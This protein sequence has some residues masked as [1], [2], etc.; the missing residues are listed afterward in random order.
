M[1]YNILLLIIIASFVIFYLNNNANDTFKGDDYI[2]NT[3]MY[4]FLGIILVII[5]AMHTNDNPTLKHYISTR[6]GAIMNMLMMFLCLFIVMMT[7]QNKPV[8]KH[9]AWTT[10]MLCLGMFIFLNYKFMRKGSTTNAALTTLILIIGLS[11]FSYSLS[12]NALPQ[13]Q[14]LLLMLLCLIFFQGFFMFKNGDQTVKHNRNTMFAILSIAL[15]SGFTVYDTQFI[16]NK[17]ISDYP[18]DSLSL[19]IDILNI[20]VSSSVLHN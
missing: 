12:S 19:G 16:K 18:A 2:T 4:V 20:F 11:W 14:Y 17:T 13:R 9:I 5:S 3:Y 6:N 15:F 1:N 8:I 7:N 10:F